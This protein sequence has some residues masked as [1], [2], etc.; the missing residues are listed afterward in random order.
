MPRTR[1]K[2]CC[3]ASSEGAE[4]APAAGAD[5]P[6]LAD[7]TLTGPGA[8]DLDSARSIMYTSPIWPLPMSLTASETSEAIQRDA[9]TAAVGA[10]QIV[11]RIS[12]NESRLLAASSLKYIQVIHVEDESALGLIDGCAPHCGAFLLDFSRPQ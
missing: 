12:P 7:P 9:K 1:V 4:M 8:V 3:I 5:P 11:R 10:V 2:I 6:G